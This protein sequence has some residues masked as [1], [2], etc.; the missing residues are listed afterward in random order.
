MAYLTSLAEI[1]SV[2]KYLNVSKTCP[3]TLYFAVH[4][5]LSMENM[6]LLLDSSRKIEQENTALLQYIIS[7]A[8]WISYLAQ[9]R[10]TST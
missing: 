3:Q 6:V 10:R 9:L 2:N 1:C 7:S 8:L 4:P 5:L